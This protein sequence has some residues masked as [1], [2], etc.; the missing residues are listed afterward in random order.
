MFLTYFVFML[1]SAAGAV[2]IGITHELFKDSA[3]S[4]L[5]VLVIALFGAVE[6]SW[7]DSMNILARLG[8]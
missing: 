1:V 2:L 8:A 4:V 6:L 3:A 7:L 5:T